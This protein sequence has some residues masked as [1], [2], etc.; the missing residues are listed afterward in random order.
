MLLPSPLYLYASCPDRCYVDV[1]RAGVRGPAGRGRVRGRGR[2]RRI[3]CAVG[4][5]PFP[6][7]G[8]C[9]SPNLLSAYGH[10]SRVP[11]R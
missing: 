11:L 5:S 4:G 9:H 2:G 10:A 8:V 6:Q 3:P 7:A 1:P